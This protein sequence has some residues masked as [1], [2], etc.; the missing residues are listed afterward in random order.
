MT[1]ADKGVEG[2]AGFTNSWTFIGLMIGVPLVIGIL[3]LA[4]YMFYSSRH[5][6]YDESW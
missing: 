5:V 3:L 4:G 2:F 6:C 1:I